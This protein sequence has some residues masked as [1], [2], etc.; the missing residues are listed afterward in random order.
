VAARDDAAGGFCAAQ[1]LDRLG[2]RL[3]IALPRQ[4][5][6]E[7]GQR[8][9]VAGTAGFCACA[10]GAASSSTARTNGGKRRRL[11][12]RDGS[13][14]GAI[15]ARLRRSR[16]GDSLTFQPFHSTRFSSSSLRA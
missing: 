15:V 6:A 1:D 12:A 4:R 14:D 9:E 13:F 16:A 10:P 8:I 7:P 3:R 5:G 2:Q 11:M